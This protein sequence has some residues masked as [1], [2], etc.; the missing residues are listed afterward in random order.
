MACLSPRTT[1][2]HTSTRVHVYT[3]AHAGPFTWQSGEN[4]YGQ[5]FVCMSLDF[6]ANGGDVETVAQHMLYIKPNTYFQ[7][8]AASAQ[9]QS[10]S[11][12]LV[13]NKKWVFAPGTWHKRFTP[14]TS[15][16]YFDTF[17]KNTNWNDDLWGD[18]VAP[19]YSSGLIVESWIRGQALGPYCPKKDK[20]HPYEV[21]DAQT[22]S[23]GSTQFSETNDHAKWAITTGSA[24][25]NIVCI[26][27][28]NRMT[29]QRK[30]GGGA[31]CL[32][33]SNLAAAL[34][35]TVATS[36]SCDKMNITYDL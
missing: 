5:T 14:S 3:H 24:A 12:G 11:L 33:S 18:L 1:H 35:A 29:S 23:V 19:F 13:V 25:P 20:T 15:R 30:R 10:P 26:G 4:I 2:F 17:G 36:D 31:V 8:I 7:N 21:V 32:L 28:I 22:L 34:K 9:T 27:D 16:M 6:P